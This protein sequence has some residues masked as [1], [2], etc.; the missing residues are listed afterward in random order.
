MDAPSDPNAVLEGQLTSIYKGKEGSDAADDGNTSE[1]LSMVYLNT[2]C[3]QV[4][5]IGPMESARTVH[6]AL[7]INASGPYTVSMG[8]RPVV[9]VLRRM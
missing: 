8:R 5:V 7:T 4:H 1:Q 9:L 3:R 2:T 6:Y